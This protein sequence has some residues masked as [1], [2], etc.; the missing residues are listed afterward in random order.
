MDSSL[1]EEHYH[2]VEPTSHTVQSFLLVASK[3]TATVQ[4]V[5][6]VLDRASAGQQAP[7]QRCPHRSPL[8]ADLLCCVAAPPLPHD[9]ARV[10]DP[11]RCPDVEMLPRLPSAVEMARVILQ[12]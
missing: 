10:L 4:D 6:R 8:T 9:Y 7:H 5:A 12:V 2:T 1:L 11:I 3:R